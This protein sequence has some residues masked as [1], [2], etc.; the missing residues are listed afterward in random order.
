[1]ER[2]VREAAQCDLWF[3]IA[4]GLP[5]P[6]VIL[7]L[8]GT[9]FTGARLPARDV[10]LDVCA[11]VKLHSNGA[12]RRASTS[13]V[14]FTRVKNVTKV[15]PPAPRRPMLSGQGPLGVRARTHTHTH[16]HCTYIRETQPSRHAS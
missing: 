11:L 12:I 5:S 15:P 7:Q 16:T 4:G 2:Q 13:S 3:H 6:H 10:L 9:P 8:Q 14:I 1:M